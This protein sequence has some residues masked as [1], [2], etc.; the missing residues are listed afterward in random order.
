MT[1]VQTKSLLDHLIISHRY[2]FPRR[3]PVP[4]PFYIDCE[5]ARLACFYFSPHADGLTLVH[6]HGN[7]EIV[8]DYVDAQ[9]QLFTRL[10]LNVFLAEYRGFGGSTGEPLLGT[11]LDDVP[12]IMSAIGIPSSRMILF[13]RSVGSIYAIHGASCFPD[14]AGLI[15]E[16]GVADPFERILLR[17]TPAE[18]GASQEQLR[19]AF[20]A[21][22]DHQR[23]MQQ[24]TQPLLVM[25]ARNDS[26]VPCDNGVRLHQWAGG[27]K[28][29]VLFDHGDHNTIMVANASEY[30]IEIRQFCAGLGRTADRPTAE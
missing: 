15:I 8:A 17:V 16:S 9:L 23:V 26:L 3:E 14:I 29:L 28:R 27:E 22:L 7:G 11:M 18:L 1:S 20:L 5:G 12:R 25:H 13:G 2:F 6:F 24:Y 4:N 21:R 30:F 19:D 10:G